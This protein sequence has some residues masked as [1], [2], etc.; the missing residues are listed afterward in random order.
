[1]GPLSL[2]TMMSYSIANAGTNMVAA[3][4]NTALPL[5]LGGYGV[6]NVAIGFL[7]QER[8]FVAGFV[9]P[10]VGALSDRTRTRLGR[11]R[12]YFLLGVPLT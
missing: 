11:R 7:A 1:M 6:P 10:V 4:A 3:L 2:A 8:S 5:Y 9:Q 12:P